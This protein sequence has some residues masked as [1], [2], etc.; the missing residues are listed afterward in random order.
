MNN[1][2]S[3]KGELQQG[4]VSGTCFT[5]VKL[6]RIDYVIFDYLPMIKSVMKKKG[7]QER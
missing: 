7:Q 5:T 6:S 2:F 3:S 4:N 1:S